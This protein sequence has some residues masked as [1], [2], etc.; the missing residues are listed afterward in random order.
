M[1]LL[2]LQRGFQDWLTVEDGSLSKECGDAV[3]PGLSVYLNNY[4]AQL[5]ACLSESYEMVRQWLGD[6]AF[7]AAAA[8]HIDTQPPHSWTLDDYALEFP[9]TLI[10]L[11][12]DDPE[13]GDLARL[14]RA[15][16]QAFVGPD[17]PSL[18][19]STLAD[20]D[21]DHAVLRPVPTFHLLQVTSNAGAIWSALSKEESPPGAETLSD[22]TQ[23]AVWREEF[24]AAFRTLSADEA[25]ALTMVSEG[26]S[27]A[28]IC[29]WQVELQGEQA[30][31]EQVGAY[32]A[33]WLADGLLAEILSA[34]SE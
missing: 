21:W 29:K 8:T 32:L 23:V 14:E 9:D 16:G 2:T 6:A 28:A 25:A 19:R 15:L 27:F 12:P 18:D 17:A 13:V 11:Y 34:P 24:T 3:L 31:A 4:R 1:N 26:A 20:V 7:S 22:P 10:A 30:G 33:N 5:L